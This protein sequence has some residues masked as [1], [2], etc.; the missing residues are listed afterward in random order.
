M[1]YIVVGCGRV[2]AELAYSL[3]NKGHKVSVI[4]QSASAFHNLHPD[5][6]G[7]VIEGDTLNRD[8]LERAGIE[9][10]DGL[11]TLTNSDPL[12]AVV[13]HIAC[14]AYRV[15]RVIA[16]NYDPRWR[17]LHEVF[18]L[19]FV[20]SSTLGAERIKALLEYPGINTLHAVGGGEVMIVEFIIPDTWDGKEYNGLLPS[21]SCS[22]VSITRAGKATLSDRTAVLAAGDVVTLSVTTEGVRAL[23]QLLESTMEED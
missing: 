11:A 7:R 13:A 18:S 9:N 15:P 4:D 17:P 12:N 5:F 23:H 21:E 3:F 1:N 8:V 16:R 10:A 20:S 19:Q 22:L 14:T 6:R 2:G